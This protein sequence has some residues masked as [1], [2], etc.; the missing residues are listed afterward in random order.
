MSDLDGRVAIVTGAAS[1][2]GRATAQV[3]AERGASV[4][5]AD[6][7]EAGAAATAALI[8]A[9]D[10]TAVVV[11]DV[12]DEAAVERMVAFAVERFGRLD[13]AQCRRI[14]VEPKPFVDHITEWRR[15]RVDLSRVCS[16]ACKP[17]SG[18]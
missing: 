4:V 7:D 10:R 6:V 11:A 18:R 9:A 8:D 12:T 15:D 1:G 5:I 2:I 13:D 16:C 3:L 17:S 14:S